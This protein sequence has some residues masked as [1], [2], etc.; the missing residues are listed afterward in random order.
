MAKALSWCVTVEVTVPSCPTEAEA[1]LFLTAAGMVHNTNPM[2]FSALLHEGSNNTSII[3]NCL[4]IVKKAK[5]SILSFKDR[6][7]D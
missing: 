4:L 2:C 1:G 6:T 7:V 5:L 3:A